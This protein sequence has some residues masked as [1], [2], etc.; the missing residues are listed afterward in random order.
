ME[1]EDFWASHWSDFATGGFDCHVI[2]GKHRE[3]LLKT[4]KKSYFLKK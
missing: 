4:L 2:E 1:K 3:I